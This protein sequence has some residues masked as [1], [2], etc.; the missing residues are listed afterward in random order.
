[1]TV[2]KNNVIKIYDITNT[3]PINLLTLDI[4]IKGKIAFGLNKI[5]FI[6]DKNTITYFEYTNFNKNN[7]NE[8]KTNYIRNF[9]FLSNDESLIII[10]YDSVDFVKNNKIVYQRKLDYNNDIILSSFYLNK[11]EII[12]IIFKSA[13]RG[14]LLK[15]KCNLEELFK[16]EQSINVYINNPININENLLNQN[17]ICEIYQFNSG[18]MLSYT[19][20]DKSIKQKD[21]IID[22]N[23]EKINIKEIKKNICDIP[24][25]ISYKNNDYSSYNCPKNK[26]Y[27]KIDEIQKELKFIK[28]RNLLERKRKVE[29]DLKKFDEIKDIKQK[30]IFLL[31]LLVN[32]NTNKDLLEKYLFFLKENNT[33][34]ND[35]FKKNYE[36][37]EKE[38]DYYSKALTIEL[39]EKLYGKEVKSQKIQFFQLIDDILTFNLDNDLEK[40]E[41]YLKSCI[42]YFENDISY[43]NMNINFSNEQLFYFRN[44]NIFKYHLKSLYNNLLKEK[45]IEKRKN[46][47]KSELEKLQHNINL[48]RDY[49][50][51][52]QDINKI[53]Y[54]L[55]LLI[56][57]SWKEE[58]ISGYYLLNSTKGDINDSLNSNEENVIDYLKRFEHVDIDLNLI[59]K[60]YKKILPSECFKSIFLELYGKDIY[61]PFE[62]QEFT[63]Y[64]VENS[65]DVLEL[66]LQNEL[67][68][69]DKFT[70]KTYFISF[71]PLITKRCKNEEKNILRNGSLV[72]TGAH[73][74]GN[75]FINIEFFME[76]CMISIEAPRKKSLE[77]SNCD[78]GKYIEYALFGKILDKIRLDQA[79]YILNEKNYEKSYLDFQFGFNNINQ[80]NLEVKGTFESL[81]KSIKLNQN[82]INYSKTIFIITNASLFKEIKISCRNE[83][84]V[85]GRVSFN[86]N[87]E[88]ELMH[89]F[90]S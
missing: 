67:G 73:E 47:L 59:K 45:D 88:F 17:E 46:L 50:N 40:F 85:I 1:M 64:F 44:I 58:F 28:C 25:F 77:I 27:F 38:L 7:I 42:N 79:L 55:L 8:Y 48:C 76:N 22:N 16:L 14:F 31:T 19:I 11:K 65:F 32:D 13:I 57:C 62:N 6:S 71:L 61:Y 90:N 29:K 15:N 86:E 69:T 43:F 82:Y 49:I 2:T 72:K 18:L 10:A 89:Y 12:I 84:D 23:F 36:T 33:A 60:F 35:I 52:S 34:L 51:N 21:S 74:I 30:Y 78:G 24:L 75:N 20:I 70:M 63:D 81:C 39:N 5:G 9:Y 56:F 66:P 68:L 54:I 53:N 4:S 41:N 83:N 87:Y 26:N 80:E 37:F 3:L